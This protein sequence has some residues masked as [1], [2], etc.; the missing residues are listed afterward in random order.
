MMSLPAEIESQKRI[1]LVRVADEML[2][3]RMHLPEGVRRIC[4]L[5][6]QIGD[7]DNP[8]FMPIRAIDSETD[9]M[10]LGE[11][12]NGCDAGYLQRVDSDM[13]AYLDQATED[14]LSA[15]REI[16]RAFG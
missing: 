11:M 9:H 13:N 4:G 15:C 12:R 6:H 1:E 5:R 2:E 3:G 7:A 16:V 8:V 14:I 10:P